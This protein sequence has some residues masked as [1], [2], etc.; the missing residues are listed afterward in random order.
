[1][2]CS[3][4]GHGGGLGRAPWRRPGCPKHRDRA[5]GRSLVCAQSPDFP[6]LSWLCH[7]PSGWQE[8]WRCRQRREPGRRDWQLWDLFLSICHE[9]GV[10][11]S[12]ALQDTRDPAASL[13]ASSA[14]QQL[15]QE[16]K[17]P[18]QGLAWLAER[19]VFL[20]RKKD[21]QRLPGQSMQHFLSPEPPT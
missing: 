13:L 11:H 20:K 12:I 2:D 19:R 21:R 8:G 1:M 5:P 10:G 16:L 3:C 9:A 7:A 17:G 4:S 18:W 14:E 6:V 15:S